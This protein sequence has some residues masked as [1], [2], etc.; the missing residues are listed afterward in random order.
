[1]PSTSHR[2][3]P[4]SLPSLV[5]SHSEHWLFTCLISNLS[6][7]LWRIR[8]FESWWEQGPL[9]SLKAEYGSSPC[10]HSL[11][12][13][14]QSGHG[15]Q[16]TSVGGTHLK[17]GI[18]TKCHRDTEMTSSGVY[19]CGDQGLVV[20]LPMV[21]ALPILHSEFSTIPFFF[22]FNLFPEKLAK[23]YFP[24]NIYLFV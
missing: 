4:L 7:Y 10:Q 22:Q 15:T 18:C 6:F 20:T 3:P 13:R 11:V 12:T 8:H 9:R 19:H 21:M 17:L 14:V 16:V 1:M 23:V 2:H 5:R 24:F